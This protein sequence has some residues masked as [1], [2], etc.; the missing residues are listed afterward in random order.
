MSI[1]FWCPDAPT[2][3]Y[4]PFPEDEPDVEDTRSVLPEIN[5]SNGNA[6]AM[7]DLMG[8]ASPQGE[9]YCG[10]VLVPALGGVIERLR[11]VLQDPVERAAALEP[12]SINGVPA[13]AT[14]L[15]ELLQQKLGQSGTLLKGPTVIS[16]GR[17]DDYLRS[18]A[19]ALLELFEAAFTHNYVVTWC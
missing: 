10:Q 11:R 18:R 2:E 13:R 17:N 7:L 3:K 9:D 6:M 4:I 5:L 14:S 1:T 19:K 16:G 15:A 8:L 12:A